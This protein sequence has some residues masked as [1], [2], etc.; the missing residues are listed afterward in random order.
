MSKN[1]NKNKINN[2]NDKIK[3]D[4]WFF[5]NGT[6]LAVETQK[7]QADSKTKII[8]IILKQYLSPHKNFI[9]K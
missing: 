9:K 3:I 7:I 6:H 1:L 2:K 8:K 4:V 5:F